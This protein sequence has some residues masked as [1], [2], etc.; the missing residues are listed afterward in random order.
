MKTRLLLLCLVALFA[1]CIYDPGNDDITIINHTP[2]SLYCYVHGYKRLNDYNYNFSF[3]STAASTNRKYDYD[4]AYNIN[5]RKILPNDTIHPSINAHSWKDVALVDSGLT[6]A[7]YKRDI[8]KL[9]ENT[10]LSPSNIFRRIDLTPKQL[11]SLKYMIIL[12]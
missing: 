11:D 9:P 6:I 7:F 10:P 2:D 5:I 4:V 8:Q 12:K 1:S 3:D